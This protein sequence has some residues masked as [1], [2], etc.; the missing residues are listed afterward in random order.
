M[1]GVAPNVVSETADLSYL[2]DALRRAG[3]PVATELTIEPLTDGR[4]AASVSRLRTRAEGGTEHCYVL[5]IVPPSSWRQHAGS[6]DTEAELWLSGVTRSLPRGVRCPT[7]DVAKHASGAWWLLMDDVSAGVVARGQYD[8]A[9]AHTLMRSLANMHARYWERDAEL[10]ALAL[11]DFAKTASA[12]AQLSPHI[13]SGATASEPWLAQL[14]QDFWVPRILLPVMLDAIAPSDADFYLDVCRNHAGVAN[15]L[16]A[17]PRTL[18]HGDLRRA[19]ISFDG[20]EAVLF[21]WEFATCAS[22][23]RDLQW[24]VFLQFWCYPPGD[25]KSLVD[26]DSLLATYLDTLDQIRGK[27]IDRA[28]FRVACDL[29]WLSALCQIGF[30]LADSLADKSAPAATVARAKQTL[31]DAIIRARRIRDQHV[32]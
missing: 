3:R 22:A 10:S 26:R 11:G 32:R 12:F 19:N 20:D 8:E 29:A 31:A 4:T 5:K 17:H 21:D 28:Q 14:S 30:C 25:G 2:R 16:A 9:K 13:A 27:P 1:S 7:I 24:F 18:V 6:N 15:A 23:A